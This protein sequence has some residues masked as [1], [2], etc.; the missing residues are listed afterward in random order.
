MFLQIGDP[1]HVASLWLSFLTIQ[2]GIGTQR[3]F[4]DGQRIWEARRFPNWVDEGTPRR[5]GRG[6]EHQQVGYMPPSSKLCALQRSFCSDFPS[7]LGADGK[8]Q[9]LQSCKKKQTPKGSLGSRTVIGMCL[10]L[11]GAKTRDIQGSRF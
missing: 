11:L 5:K 4:A 8:L 10:V 9:V 6:W 3:E 7:T 2:K 1:S